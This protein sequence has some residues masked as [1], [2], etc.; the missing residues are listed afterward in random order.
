MRRF[1]S[2]ALVALL[3]SATLLGCSGKSPSNEPTND[4]G[5]NPAPTTRSITIAQGVDALTLDPVYVTDTATGNVQA[6]LFDT[7]LRRL[8]DGTVAPGLAL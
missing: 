7:V 3:L 5:T 6:G 1:T 2:L 4:P 8:P